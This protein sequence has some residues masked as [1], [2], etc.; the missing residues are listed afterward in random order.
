MPLF[1][2]PGERIGYTVHR[3]VIGAPPLFLIHGFTASAASFATNIEPL[4]EHF[5]VV[6]VELLGHG[7]SEA[8]EGPQPYG[9]G[10]AVDRILG[11][12]DHLG[13]ERALLCGHS[14]GGALALRV[15]LDAPER[16]AGLVVINSN[17][18]AGT[19]AWREAARLGMGEIAAR[20]RREGKDFIKKTRL[21]PAH[22]RRLP[23]AIREQLARDFDRM[24]DAGVAGTA[25]ALTVEVNAY[26]RLPELRVPAL[27]VIGELD[28]D[29]VQNAPHF[30]GRMPQDKVRAVTI[31]GGGHAAN[32]ERREAFE[33]GLLEFASEIGYL[34]RPRAGGQSGRSNAQPAGKKA[35]N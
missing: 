20:V 29:F 32:V 22:S 14:L 16:L 33:A 4:K 27:V 25:E 26:E 31:E 28:R 3:G 12:M 19:P 21:Y 35:G 10:P 9:P 5:T 18:A 7:D 6:I 30:I 2:R 13:Y 23:P 15:A 34:E 11:L 8:P 24:D 17:S 1:G